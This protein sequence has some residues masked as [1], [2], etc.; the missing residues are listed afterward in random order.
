MDN[1]KYEFNKLGITGMII[2][3]ASGLIFLFSWLLGIGESIITIDLIF[4]KFN[5][6]VIDLFVF[7]IFVGILLLPLGL[8]EKKE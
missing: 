7:F 5:I 1:S 3:L 2:S 6:A 8:R 4:T